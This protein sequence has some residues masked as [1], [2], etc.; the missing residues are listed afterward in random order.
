[1]TTSGSF[2]NRSNTEI[3]VRSRAEA[4]AESARAAAE[5][6]LEALGPWVKDSDTTVE[7][8]SLELVE[9]GTSEA[10]LVKL[11]YGNEGATVWLVGA[12][13]IEGDISAAATR[14]MLNALNRKL[15][16]IRSQ[17]LL[18]PQET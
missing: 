16:L 12:A 6:V 14:A 18:D 8:D 9:I 4:S 1:M 11:L 13:L 7:I 3:D 10:V 17:L 5:A 15:A 2:V